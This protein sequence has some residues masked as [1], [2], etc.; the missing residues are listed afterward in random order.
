MLGVIPPNTQA[1]A[2]LTYIIPVFIFVAAVAY[3]FFVR[4]RAS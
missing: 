4:K 2:D 3:G 1:G